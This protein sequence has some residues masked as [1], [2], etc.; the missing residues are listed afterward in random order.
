MHEYLERY[1]GFMGACSDYHISDV[2]MLGVPMDFTV[3]FR[4]GTR[5]GPRRIREVSEG[6]E[7]YSPYLDRELGDYCY[8]DAGD[9]VLPFGHVQESLR[10]LETVVGMLLNDAKFPIILG[11]EHLISIAPIKEVAKKYPN[12]AV[13]HFDAHADL[14][15]D[16]MGEGLSHA[17]VMRRV[18]EVVG[19]RNVYQFGIRSGTR[20]EFAFGRENT[21]FY[22]LE[23]LPPLRKIIPSLQGRP[24]YVT[25]DID[26]VDPAFAPGTGTPEP[27]GCNA[28]EIIK[29]LHL[30]QELNVVGMDL[31][32][33]CPVYDQSDRTSLLAAKLVREAI[34]IFG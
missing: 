27:G 4:P 2:V 21:C 5:S 34:L 22:P 12:L 24:V 30:M 11:G 29:A 33:V 6:L 32:E 1:G 10:R 9:I 16:Y 7:E 20:D 13:L 17:T 18:T 31:V 15:D 23:I 26:V 8:Y 14:R 19:T 25:L 3:S 28:S